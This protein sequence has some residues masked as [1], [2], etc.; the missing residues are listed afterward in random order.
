MGKLLTCLPRLTLAQ[1]RPKLRSTIQ[2][3]RA[4]E[5]LKT[6]QCPHGRLTIC[7]LFLQGGGVYVSSGMVTIT[8]SSIT[9]NTAAGYVR[10]L[11]KTS[12][13]PDGK[14]ADLLATTHACTTA[15]ETPVNYTVCTCRR[16]LENFPM[17]HWEIHVLLVACRAVESQSGVAQ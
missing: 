8:S 6:S 2:Y 3:V 4:A 15:A 5:T 17:P 10:A 11:C 1:L 16:D 14:V 9:G 12:N 13:R 7:V